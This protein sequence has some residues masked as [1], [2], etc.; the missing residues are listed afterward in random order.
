MKKILKIFIIVSILMAG[1][2]GGIVYFLSK[3]GEEVGQFDSRR[4]LDQSDQEDVHAY[5]FETDSLATPLEREGDEKNVMNFDD[6]N[7]FSV[8]H[9]KDSRARLDRLI[10]R[11]NPDFDKPL[12]AYNPFGTLP[13]TYYFYFKTQSPCM[14]RYTITVEDE[15]IPDHI[16]YINN[17]NTKNLGTEHEFIVGGLIPG[18]RNYIIL[19][20]LDGNGSHREDITYKVDVPDLQASTQVPHERGKSD[21]RLQNGLF[22]LLPKNDKSIYI[23]DNNGILR[24]AL[25]TESEHGG[26]VYTNDSHVVYQTAGTHVV[27][28]DRLGQVEGVAVFSGIK[29]ILDFAY[30]DYENVF[31][32]IQNGK[33]YQIVRTSMKGGKTQ[34]VYTFEK[35]M[36]PTSLS[37]VVGGNLYVSVSNPMGIM[38]IDGLLSERPKVKLVVGLKNDWKD[39][40]VKKRVIDP[41]APKKKKKKSEDDKDKKTDEAEDA[42]SGEAVRPEIKPEG[43]P[44]LGWD[45]SESVLSLVREESNGTVDTMTFAVNKNRLVYAIKLQ[46]DSKKKEVKMFLNK[47]TEFEGRVFVQW[48]PS[49]HV[50][51]GNGSR[52]TYEERDGDFRV[53]REFTVGGSFDGVWKYSLEGLCFYP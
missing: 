14:V 2:G 39:T 41:T 9:S 36:K 46:I 42:A 31:A 40:T 22:F 53:T 8:A 30:D 52:G 1:A 21:Y 49:G 4:H 29:S 26:R 34:L 13:N 10:R 19:E 16:R 43:M 45:M 35:G 3:G 6:A 37:S 28:L 27:R 44:L 17:G 33:R 7:A 48:D 18:M 24:G 12:I 38:R 11:S 51:I 20:L 15:K 5:R 25:G 32:L 50:I 23:Y 47:E